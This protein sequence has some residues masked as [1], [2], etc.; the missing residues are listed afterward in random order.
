MAGSEPPVAGFGLGER[1]LQKLLGQVLSE[2]GSGG[3]H[4]EDPPLAVSQHQDVATALAEYL[5]G[6]VLNG[7]AVV[8]GHQCAHVGQVGQQL[9]G[10]REQSISLAVENLE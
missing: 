1:A 8:G 6:S 3:L 5:F 10:L 7:G 4:T 9:R 2:T